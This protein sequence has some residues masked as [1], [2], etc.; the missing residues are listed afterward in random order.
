M[1]PSKFIAETEPTRLAKI[2]CLDDLREFFRVELDTLTTVDFESIVGDEGIEWTEG[3]PIRF[4]PETG[5]A[6]HKVS[7]EGLAYVLQRAP[8][9]DDTMQRDLQRLASFVQ[10]SEA[11]TIFEVTYLPEA[12]EAPN[13]EEMKAT[14]EFCDECGHSI[15]SGQAVIRSKTDTDVVGAAAMHQTVH[16]ALCPECAERYDDT[17]NRMLWGMS[18]FVMLVLLIALSGWCL[19]W[20]TR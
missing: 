13:A 15:P 17:G 6:I 8:A 5:L 18:V 12:P 1:L 2:T 20:M 16:L 10:K 11:S 19:Q 7:E 4:D 3:E 9:L 14:R